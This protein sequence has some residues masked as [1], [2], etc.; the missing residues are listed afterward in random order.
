M[1]FLSAPLVGAFAMAVAAVPHVPRE[2]LA[3]RSWDLRLLNTAIPTCN[4]KDSNLDASIYH[5][6]GRYDSTCETLEADYNATNVKS[7]SWKSPSEDDWHDLC[8]F[9][10]A[11]CSGGESTFLGSITDGWE[12]CYP[13]N[14]F[15]GWS[16][17]SHGTAC[18]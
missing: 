1:R 4:P 5:R 8:M 18:V 12:V 11:D 14:G 3:Y 6:Y 2:V 13:Y 9:S 15:R 7:V 16:V 10:T 17:V